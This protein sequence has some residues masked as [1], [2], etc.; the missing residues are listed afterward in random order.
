MY[1]CLKKAV[2]KEFHAVILSVIW[3]DKEEK[4]A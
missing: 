2:Q 4:M 1:N 3:G